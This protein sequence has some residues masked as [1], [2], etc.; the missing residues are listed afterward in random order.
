MDPLFNTNFSNTKNTNL[1]SHNIGSSKNNFSLNSDFPNNSHY[2]YTSEIKNNYNF[3]NT[4]NFFGFNFENDDLII[5]ALLFFL[6]N[7]K[8]D[9]TFLFIGLI[10]LLLN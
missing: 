6:Y 8:I 5:L 4:Y 2:N 7:E 10:L 3:T 9:D 1:N